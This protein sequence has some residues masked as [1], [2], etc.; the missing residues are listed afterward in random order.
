[1]EYEVFF[2]DFTSWVF[3][4]AIADRMDRE[5][6]AAGKGYVSGVG[7]GDNY[8]WWLFCH[9][10]EAEVGLS[11]IRRLLQEMRARPTTAIIQLSYPQVYLTLDEDDPDAE[12]QGHDS[13]TWP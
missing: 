6:G 11:L 9:T 13:N 7:N 3:K 2:S 5:L 10:T 4:S 12:E 8:V 1:V